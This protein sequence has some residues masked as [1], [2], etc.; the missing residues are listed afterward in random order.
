MR[1]Q[2]LLLESGVS[3]ARI[4]DLCGFCDVY[5]LGREFKRLVG[6]PPAAWRR[7]EIGAATKASQGRIVGQLTNGGPSGRKRQSVVRIRG[8]SP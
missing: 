6:I 1:A 8:Y 7:S 5:H 4:A 2:L 3:L